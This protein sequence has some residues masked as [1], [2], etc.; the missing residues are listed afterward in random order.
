MSA[1]DSNITGVCRVVAETSAPV[2]GKV[3]R[4]DHPRRVKRALSSV[5]EKKPVETPCILEK[6]RDVLARRARLLGFCPRTML[7]AHQLGISLMH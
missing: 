4:S 7:F 5:G 1:N 3:P 6:V 2:R